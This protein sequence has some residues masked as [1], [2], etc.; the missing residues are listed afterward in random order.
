[1]TAE[2]LLLSKA[3][4]LDVPAGRYHDGRFVSIVDCRIAQSRRRSSSF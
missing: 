2:L 1:M 4:I 3:R